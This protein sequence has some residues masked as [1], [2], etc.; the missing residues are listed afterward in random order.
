MRIVSGIIFLQLLVSCTTTVHRTP[1]SMKP[2]PALP[3]APPTPAALP[4]DSDLDFRMMLSAAH[5]HGKNWPETD[6]ARLE[7]WVRREVGA[8]ISRGQEGE[9]FTLWLPYA[10]WMQAGHAVP[11]PEL[12]RLTVKLLAAFQKMGS[13]TRTLQIIHF[14]DLYAPGEV[15]NRDTI[16]WGMLEL[17]RVRIEMCRFESEEH[18]ERCVA[19]SE[20]EGDLFKGVPPQQASAWIPLLQEISFKLWQVPRGT[21]FA[22][23]PAWL[24]SAT[25]GLRLH[26]ADRWFAMCLFTPGCFET[27]SA[28]VISAMEKLNP[29]V[30]D[31]WKNLLSDKADPSRLEALSLY[32]HTQLGPAFSG[33]VCELTARRFPGHPQMALCAQR[34]FGRI[35]YSHLQRRV[36]VDQ[37][38]RTPF[39]RELWDELFQVTVTRFYH[40]VERE[41]L[42]LARQE[43]A[44]LQ[45]LVKLMEARW[46]SDAHQS[47][48][49][50]QSVAIVDLYML[51]GEIDLARTTCE[52]TFARTQDPRILLSWFRLE[53]WTGQYAKAVELMEKLRVMAK[54]S[55]ATQYYFMK[56]ARYHA[57]ALERLGEGEKAGQLR[58]EAAHFFRKLFEFINDPELR[59]EVVVD[60]GKLYF[61]S[62]NAENGLQLFQ[63][64]LTRSPTCDTIG[65]ILQTLVTFEQVD[66][67]FDVY[68]TLMD[69]EKCR[70]NRRLYSSI[71]MRFFGL[72]FAVTDERMERVN[73][74]LDAY[75]GDPWSD[76]LAA[77]TRERLPSAKLIEKAENSGQK[78]EALYYSGLA[79][80][81]RGDT[82]TAFELFHKVLDLRIVNYTEHEFS[83]WHIEQ[84]KRRPPAEPD[85]GFEFPH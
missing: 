70:S 52:T 16:L 1:R 45:H 80:W 24:A 19:R 67:A 64:A 11:T 55:V 53:F 20:L 23:V 84:Q 5:F 40:F 50:V 71:W 32:V 36:L 77:F 6:R 82:K 79:A 4:L 27:P 12:T 58:F 18:P 74:F 30:H 76:D 2:Q 48:L 31:A 41:H 22:Q 42:T 69:H 61:D 63:A 13:A 10:Q 37:I 9:A 73:Q 17:E 51:R 43:Y 8:R 49:T 47:A 14:L 44:Y 38:A 72:R 34:Q 3:D 39:V 83:F 21:P 57:V 66:A 75:T 26:G 65:T 59:T 68:H 33:R 28:E 85:K 29:F 7:T 60:I 46:P 15:P 54:D 56:V 81:S 25:S 78:A 62:G 35:E